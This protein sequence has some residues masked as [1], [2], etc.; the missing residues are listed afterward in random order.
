M[1]TS[2][3]MIRKI[4]TFEVSQRTLDGYFEAT[5]LLQQWNKSNKDKPKRID[6]FLRNEK[7]IEFIEQI[8]KEENNHNLLTIS[9]GEKS[10]TDNQVVIIIKGRK[11]KIGQTPQRVFMHPYLFIDF[12]M[13]LNPKFKY[14]VIKFVY[15]QLI[16]YRHDVGDLYIG[17]SRAI[18]I[19]KNVNYSQ[20]AKGLNYIIFGNHRKN[21]RQLASE[22][23][24]KKL[25]DLQSKLAFAV[26]MGYIKTYDELINEMRKIYHDNWSKF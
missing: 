12:A 10:Y 4:G 18:S 6:E 8:K 14:A 24:L 1:K 23:Q 2:V 7:T 26:D 22:N 17:L 25:R 3:N 11:T 13:W 9:D 15:D 20:V 16:E 21:L 5:Q 19:F